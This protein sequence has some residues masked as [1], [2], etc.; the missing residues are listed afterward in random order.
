MTWK[1][2]LVDSVIVVGGAAAFAALLLG[3]GLLMREPGGGPYCDEL[4][5]AKGVEIVWCVPR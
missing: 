3:F 4:P 5:P 2:M 1:S